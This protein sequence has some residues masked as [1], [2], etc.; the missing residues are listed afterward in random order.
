MELKRYKVDNWTHSTPV[1]V[2]ESQTGEWIRVSDHAAAM[3]EKDREMSDTRAALAAVRAQLEADPQVREFTRKALEEAQTTIKKMRDVLILLT[4]PE[5]E[6]KREGF[7]LW[8]DWSKAYRIWETG[9]AAL[10]PTP[11]HKETPDCCA[12]GLRKPI[13]GSVYCEGC[14]LR[15]APKQSTE[16][17]QS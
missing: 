15:R 13:S 1:D 12:C 11:E 14:F 16:G 5:M 9:K 8:S 10:F 2:R 4:S 3:A 6:P 17:G 7:V